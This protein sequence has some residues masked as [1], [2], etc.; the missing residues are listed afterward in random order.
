M[1]YFENMRYFLVR[2]TH[3]WHGIRLYWVARDYELIGQAW[4]KDGRYAFSFSDGVKQYR[5]YVNGEETPF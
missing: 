5:M 2:L 4:H 3:C 1:N